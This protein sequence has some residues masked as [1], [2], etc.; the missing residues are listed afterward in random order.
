MLGWSVERTRERL[1]HGFGVLT[2][3]FICSL[4]CIMSVNMIY[5]ESVYDDI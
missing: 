3:I 2:R 1:I 5:N 4:T